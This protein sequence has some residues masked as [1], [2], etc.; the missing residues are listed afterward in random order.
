MRSRGIRIFTVF[1]ALLIA[2]LLSAIT[3]PASATEQS[4][5]RQAARGVRQ[6]TRQQ[7]RETK[8]DCRA[9]DQKSNAQCRQDKRNTKQGGREK[10]RDIKY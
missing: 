10:A 7:A 3:G 5:Q 1:P 8:E 6:D 9:N 4:E 2:A